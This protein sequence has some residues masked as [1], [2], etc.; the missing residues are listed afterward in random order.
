MASRARRSVPKARPKAARRK[1]YHHGDLRPALI[2]ATLR[3]IEEEGPE[4]VT[5]RAAAKRAGVS[6]GAPFRH[7]PNRTALM[8]AVAE[9]ATARFVAEIAGAQAEIG[10]DDPL[11]HLFAIGMAY[12]RWAVRN[13]AH[14]QVVSTRSFIDYDG[15]QSLRRDNDAIR[16]QMDDLLAEAQRRGLLHQADIVHIPLAAR[17][18]VYGLA[19]MYADGH[20]AQWAVPGETPEQ[21]MRAVL[22]L[23]ITGL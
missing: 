2:A 23:F 12:L 22:A 15:S 13:P 10:G 11:A 6:S 17:A 14:F 19:R 4:N 20:F 3:L 9:E 16:Q 21:A 5:V 18:M 7:F 1:H 8:T